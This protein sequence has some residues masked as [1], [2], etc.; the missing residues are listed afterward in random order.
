MGDG[1]RQRRDQCRTSRPPLPPD[2]RASDPP[3][4]PRRRHR[5]R[6]LLDSPD[7]G[8]HPAARDAL[9]LGGA[10]GRAAWRRRSVPPDARVRRAECLRAREGR[11]S[12]QE[13]LRGA[14]ERDIRRRRHRHR[15][16]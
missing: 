16:L 4:A 11:R 12:C 1:G 3:H 8:D 13:L 2:G 6:G 7:R 9:L 15:R 5:L 14:A 10:A